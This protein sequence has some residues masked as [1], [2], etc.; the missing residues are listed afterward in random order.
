[1]EYSLQMD[2]VPEFAA[3]LKR[4]GL[5]EFFNDFSPSHQRGYLKWIA[6]AKR[7]DTKKR[8]IE[9]AMQMLAKKRGE[10]VARAKR[11]D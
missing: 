4:A 5:A 2:R 9:K 3:A 11:R 1:M 10:S 6:E 7:P 8:R